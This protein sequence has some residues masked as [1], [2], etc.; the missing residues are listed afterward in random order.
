MS[1]KIKFNKKQNKRDY[2][3]HIGIN[4]FF[5]KKLGQKNSYKVIIN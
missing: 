1:R 2:D 3:S 5:E 4:I